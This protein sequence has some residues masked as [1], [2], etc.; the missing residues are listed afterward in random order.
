MFNNL[1]GLFVVEAPLRIQPVADGEEVVA[2]EVRGAQVVA[3]TP[4]HLAPVRPAAQVPAHLLEGP[5]VRLVGHVDVLVDRDV[6][7]VP[8]APVGKS[9]LVG[10]AEPDLQWDDFL[11][12]ILSTVD[13]GVANAGAVPSLAEKCQLRLKVTT[14]V[15]PVAGGN[16]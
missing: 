16:H 12:R 14:P 10:R 11:D 7:V 3:D 6:G 9:H 4:A 13:R 15:A 1:S 2:A 8:P 5:E